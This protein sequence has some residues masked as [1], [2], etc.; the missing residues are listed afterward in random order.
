MYVGRQN[1]GVTEEMTEILWCQN[2]DPLNVVVFFL[3]KSIMTDSEDTTPT[4]EK[5]KKR[6]GT[7]RQ[8]YFLLLV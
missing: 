2:V 6:L 4:K 1:G 3:K 5:R 8:F 7:Y